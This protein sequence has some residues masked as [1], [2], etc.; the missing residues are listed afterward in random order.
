MGRG[1]RL[2]IVLALAAICS[3]A[4]CEPERGGGGGANPPANPLTKCRTE[5]LSPY[6]PQLTKQRLIKG[7]ARSTCR[8]PID[9]HSVTLHL[10]RKSPSGWENKDTEQST[11]IPTTPGINLLVITECSPGTWRLL[12]CP[13][14]T[15][16]W[17]RESPNGRRDRISR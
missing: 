16:E 5:F 3:L 4:G 14:Q 13:Q 10:Q 11:K 12:D 1:A 9:S 2:R 15:D 8:E 6:R 7:E 17:S